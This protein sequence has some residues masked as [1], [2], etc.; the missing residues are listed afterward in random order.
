MEVGRQFWGKELVFN[1]YKKCSILTLLPLLL[2]RG[3]EKWVTSWD[4][5]TLVAIW[6]MV[7]RLPFQLSAQIYFYHLVDRR[8]QWKGAAHYHHL[9][10]C[11]EDPFKETSAQLHDRHTWWRLGPTC[12]LRRL[13]I[14]CSSLQA[15]SES[16]CVGS[17]NSLIR[18]KTPFSILKTNWRESHPKRTDPV[19]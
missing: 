8:R 10:N 12:V 19:E 15:L 7:V 5:G 17:Y 3:R 18:L 6:Q 9:C 16:S 2:E 4:F 14:S 13:K 11:W 1:A